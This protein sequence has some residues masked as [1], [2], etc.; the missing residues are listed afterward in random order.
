MSDPVNKKSLTEAD[1]RTKYITPA[2]LGPGNL[3]WDSMT[4]VREEFYFTKGRV[5]VQGKTVKRGQAKKIDYLLF[6]KP[7]IPIAVIEAKDNNHEIGAGMQQALE[8]AE[9]LDV[10]FAYSS[11]GDG[12]LEHDRTGASDPVERQ[13]SLDE[14]PPPGEL[15]T[16]Y[17]LAKGLSPAQES[18]AKQEY[19]DDGTG[20]SPRYYQLNAINRTVEAIAHGENRI[21][22]VMATGTGKTYTAFQIIWRLW[23]WNVCRK[24]EQIS[25]CCWV[26]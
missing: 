4:Q 9:L 20:K 11:N 5:M 14:F 21:L 7:N 24:H 2:V 1:I 25:G 12:F 15:W 23:K 19:Y 16:R 3:N 10:P 22:L 13:I 8:Y 6:Y 18:I 17:C 26:V